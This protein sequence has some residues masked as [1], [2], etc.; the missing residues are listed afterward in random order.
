MKYSLSFC[1]DW[2]ER[3]NLCSSFYIDCFRQRN[4]MAH[5]FAFTDF[6]GG[7]IAHHFALTDFNE[8]TAANILRWLISTKELQLIILHWLTSMKPRSISEFS[9]RYHITPKASKVNN[10]I[11]MHIFVCINCLFVIITIS[12]SRQYFGSD[13]TCISSWPL[14]RCDFLLRI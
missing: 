13:F 2:F 4:Y 7:T 12:V 8:G 1:I 9:G 10:C 3:R 11:M 6:K 5:Q 14:L